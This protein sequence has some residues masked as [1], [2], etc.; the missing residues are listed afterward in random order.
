MIDLGTLA[1][2]HEHRH[3][4]HA[5][6]LRCD[7]WTVLPLG[8]MVAHGKGSL[9]LPLALRCRDCGQAGQLQVRPPMPSNPQAVGWVQPAGRAKRPVPTHSGA[10]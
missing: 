10:V 8:L 7:R 2:L 3:E 1:G 5:Y 6:C 9:R 4:L